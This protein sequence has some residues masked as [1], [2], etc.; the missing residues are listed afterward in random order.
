M[1]RS[2]LNGVRNVCPGQRCI[3]FVSVLS[4][5]FPIVLL[6]SLRGQEILR[7]S[8]VFLAF[9]T[10]SWTVFAVRPQ[11]TAHAIC[12]FCSEAAKR[13]NTKKRIY[14]SNN[15]GS[16]KVET[17]DSPWNFGQI[18]PT[19]CLWKVSGKVERFF[20]HG[21]SGKFVEWKT[22]VCGKNRGKPAALEIP[23]PQAVESTFHSF[24]PQIPQA[25]FCSCQMPRTQRALFLHM[26]FQ[27]TVETHVENLPTPVEFLWNRQKSTAKS[28]FPHVLQC[29]FPVLYAWLLLRIFLMVSSTSCFRWSSCFIAVSML[30]ME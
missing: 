26:N 1:D 2:I 12:C 10:V 11:C 21:K 6:Q 14:S 5:V 18:F 4:D 17:A 19:D 27:Q 8:A 25:R 7:S 29:P 22:K 28:C 13:Q 15:R 20:P 16:G 3:R 24:L 23:L 30:L 9:A